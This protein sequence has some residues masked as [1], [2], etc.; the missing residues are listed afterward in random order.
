MTANGSEGLAAGAAETERL[1][2][3]LL[4]IAR[5]EMRVAELLMKNERLRQG[6]VREPLAD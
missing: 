2:A 3:A 4:Q 5:L 6:A 1:R